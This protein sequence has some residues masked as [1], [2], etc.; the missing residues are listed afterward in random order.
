MNSVS[1]CP[2]ILEN[3]T[4][5]CADDFARK[6]PAVVH[7]YGTARPRIVT[8]GSNCFIWT[9]LREWEDL[10]GEMSLVNTSFNA[11]EEPIV[12]TFDEGAHGLATGMIDELWV[13]EGD[14]VSRYAKSA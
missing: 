5:D 6:R 9:A 3:S 7:V 14:E 2:T 10:S 1:P 12:C 11:H 4:F 13:V 8:K